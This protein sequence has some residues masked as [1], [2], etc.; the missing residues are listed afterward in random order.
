MQL[1]EAVV[2]AGPEQGTR[3]VLL[4]LGRYGEGVA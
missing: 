1:W 4:E 3:T 2:S